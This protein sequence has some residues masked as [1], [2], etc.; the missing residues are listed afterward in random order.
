MR[1]PSNSLRVTHSNRSVIR[2]IMTVG[3][4][5]HAQKRTR[6]GDE[7]KSNSSLRLFWCPTFGQI[8]FTS[9]VKKPCQLHGKK[10]SLVYPLC[11]HARG[12]PVLDARPNPVLDVRA[13]LVLKA[14]RNLLLEDDQFG[15]ILLLYKKP[16]QANVSDLEP[17]ESDSLPNR[18]RNQQA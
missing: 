12:N 8:N 6:E 2:L 18:K 3:E 5:D 11:S 17:Q 16:L 7:H 1:I 9:A 4:K 15:K 13:N 10:T 14:G